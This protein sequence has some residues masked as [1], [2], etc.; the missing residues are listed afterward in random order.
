MDRRPR[1]VVL[2]KLGRPHGVKGEVRFFPFNDE[3]QSLQ[4]GLRGQL[5]GAGQPPLEVEVEQ[6]R[7]SPKFAIVKFDQ[8]RFRDEVDAYKHAKFHVLYDELPPLEDDDDFYHV[9]LMGAP[10]YLADSEDGDPPEDAEP[11]GEV[12]R[13]FATGANDVMVVTLSTGKELLVPLVEHAVVALD[14]DDHLVI[15]QPFQIWT[16]EDFEWSQD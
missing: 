9:E 10:V 13:F 4:A 7:H 16:P 1:R 8:F 11:I 14:L 15:L 12:K 3:T 6:V 5:E 2:G